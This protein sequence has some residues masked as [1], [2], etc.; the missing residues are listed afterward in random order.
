MAAAGKRR[1]R[2][3]TLITK[4]KKFGVIEVRQRG[5]HILL[6]LP[7]KPGSDKG[8]TYPLACHKRTVEVSI[9]VIEATLRKFGI[10][11]EKFWSTK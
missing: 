5:S 7:E 8:P 4:L 11:E 3:Q 2:C 1:L 9:H 6:L 10:D